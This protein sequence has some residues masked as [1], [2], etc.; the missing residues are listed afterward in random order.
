MTYG[1]KETC[2][3]TRR[4]DT[5]SQT[6]Y[7]LESVQTEC[8]ETDQNKNFYFHAGHINIPVFDAQDLKEERNHVVLQEETL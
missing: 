2:T 3:E 5:M 8:D 6:L 1:M 7:D 4:E